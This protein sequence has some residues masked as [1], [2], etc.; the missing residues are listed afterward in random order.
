MALS[1][2]PT[3]VPRPCCIDIYHQDAVV[4]FAEVKAAGIDF[5]WHKCS[6]GLAADP[7]YMHRRQAF[8][9]NK[10]KYFG[11]YHFFHGHD[12]KAE[13]EF[14]VNHAEVEDGLA[15]AIDWEQLRDGTS[16]KAPQAA[17]FLEE[18][19]T[20][21]AT[22]KSMWVYGGNVLKENIAG[23]DQAAA[24]YW[25]QFY[26]WLCQYGPHFVLPD[27]W[28]GKAG[29]PDLWQNN[30]D[31]SG[32]GPHRIPGISGFCDN[33]CIVDGTEDD[34]AAKWAA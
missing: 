7:L 28:R 13:A 4:D 25:Q 34:L 29:A 14:F 18:V 31:Q 3:S 12:P 1:G 19:L 10:V 2:E 33:S 26:L 24:S 27:A 21:V 30:G 5:V 8:A 23:H 32:P 22:R 16:A 9:D 20:L 17:A 11:A 6:E 15:L